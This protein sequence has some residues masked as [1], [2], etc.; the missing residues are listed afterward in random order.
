MGLER[1]WTGG[2]NTFGWTNL[3][4]NAGSTDHQVAA[5]ERYVPANAH[6]VRMIVSGGVT[7]YGRTQ[8]DQFFPALP[9]VWTNSIY[10]T[11]GAE[12]K[13][14][15]LQA[16]SMSMNQAVTPRD[17][18]A[19]TGTP[20]CVSTSYGSVGIDDGDWHFY[21]SMLIGGVHDV[22]GADGIAAHFYDYIAH[23]AFKLLYEVLVP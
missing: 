7:I 21:S 1:I 18:T 13:Q 14:I 17:P 20:R 5:C 3:T 15:N 12:S 10:F 9:H 4:P 16:G 6:I 2:V 11:H 8:V 23:F 22:D 19:F